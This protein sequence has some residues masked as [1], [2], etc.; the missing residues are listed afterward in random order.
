M[1]GKENL[2]RYESKCYLHYLTE[3]MLLHG[4]RSAVLRPLSLSF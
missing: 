2:V 4:Q 3:G 1:V